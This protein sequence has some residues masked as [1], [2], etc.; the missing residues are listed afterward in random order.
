MRALQA[1][2]VKGELERLHEQIAM[3][4][5]VSV[6]ER[7]CGR[8]GRRVVLKTWRHLPACQPAQPTNSPASERL[9]GALHI[10]LC[11]PTLCLS[12]CLASQ[13]P[14]HCLPAPVLPQYVGPQEWEKKAL[15]LKE[16]RQAVLA[17]KQ[18][19]GEEKAAARKRRRWARARAP[20]G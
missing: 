8:D 3:S 18:A 10:R 6:R 20:S 9:K 19:A 5:E 17:A 13:P 7:A 1:A 14:S 16:A 4:D 12:G 2:E 15:E 11:P